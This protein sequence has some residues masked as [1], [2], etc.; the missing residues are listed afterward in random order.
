MSPTASALVFLER[1]TDEFT[2]P[3]TPR[4][5]RSYTGG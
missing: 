2:A 1:M 3:G 4:L 5:P